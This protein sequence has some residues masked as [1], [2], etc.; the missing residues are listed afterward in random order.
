MFLGTALGAM[1]I[2][3][4]GTIVGAET[5]HPN[6]AADTLTTS[7]DGRCSG[8]PPGGAPSVRSG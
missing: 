1:S 3:D 5:T 8:P 6:S 7:N 4:L 2:F